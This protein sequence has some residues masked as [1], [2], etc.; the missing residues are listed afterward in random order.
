MISKWA[1]VN[2]LETDIRIAGKPTNSA[3][4]PVDPLVWFSFLPKQEDRVCED[5]VLAF[6]EAD[7]F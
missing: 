3:V 4:V 2:G 1:T 7:R 5:I 6:E